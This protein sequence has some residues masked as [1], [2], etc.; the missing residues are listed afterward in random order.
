VIVIIAFLLSML[1]SLYFLWSVMTT[2]PG[3]IPR[4]EVPDWEAQMAI[5]SV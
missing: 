2:D 4:K 1:L 5:Q 3:I